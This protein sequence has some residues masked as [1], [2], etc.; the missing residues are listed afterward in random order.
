MKY[1]YMIRIIIQCFQIIFVDQL[2]VTGWGK[3]HGRY[4]PPSPGP[5]AEKLSNLTGM[6]KRAKDRL[7]PYSWLLLWAV[8]VEKFLDFC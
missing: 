4:S 5:V 6:G 8:S 1:N 2:P 7:D 3:E